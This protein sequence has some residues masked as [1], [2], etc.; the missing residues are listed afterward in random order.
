[1]QYKLLKEAA[2]RELKEDFD[3]DWEPDPD[4]YVDRYQTAFPENEGAP[5]LGRKELNGLIAKY[6]D[7]RK[8]GVGNGEMLSRVIDH[9]DV[10]WQKFQT[11]LSTLCK[12]FWKRTGWIKGY[13]VPRMM[14]EALIHQARRWERPQIGENR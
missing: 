14:N 6:K 7:R 10:E 11:D 8:E 4:S 3:W 2:L 1:M 13:D 5:R 12:R 9:F